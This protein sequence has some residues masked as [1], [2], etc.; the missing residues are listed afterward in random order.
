MQLQRRQ[1]MSLQM[2]CARENNN[3]AQ[4][5]KRPALQRFWPSPP[6]ALWPAAYA[7][8][9]QSAPGLF[10]SYLP[11]ESCSALGMPFFAGYLTGSAGAV[12]VFTPDSSTAQLLCLSGAITGCT[13]SAL[14]TNYTD[15]WL[16]LSEPGWGVTIL[17]HSSGTAFIVWYS[18]DSVGNPKWYFASSCVFNGN[19]CSGSLYETHGPPFAPTFN[20]AQVSVNLVGYIEF[21]FSTPNAGIMS[22]N[23]HGI[24]G[25]KSIVRFGY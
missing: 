13:T 1:S 22:Y 11:T 4:L 5:P 23:V 21:D 10:Q 3:P 14:P 17:H 12:S 2:A 18:Y 6:S 19:A 24:T 15:L 16:N 7:L 20:S 8:L 9:Q 25:T